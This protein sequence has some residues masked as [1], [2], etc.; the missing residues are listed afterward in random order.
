VERNSQGAAQ[1]LANLRAALGFLLIEPRAPELQLLHRWLD[2][3]EG[4]G[5][6]AVGVERHGYLFSL[7]HIGEGEW[8]AT[9]SEHPMWSSAGYGIANTPWEATQ[10]AARVALKRAEAAG[11]PASA[12]NDRLNLPPERSFESPPI[13]VLSLYGFPAAVPASL[14]WSTPSL[15]LS[16]PAFSFSR[17]R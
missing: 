6:I 2:S 13:H 15:G 1:C 11:S 10:I 8:R 16:S 9:F 17:R 4:V 14:P 5:L 3:W 7:S 12:V